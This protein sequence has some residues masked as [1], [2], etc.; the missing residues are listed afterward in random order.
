[1]TSIRTV[2]ISDCTI[3]DVRTVAEIEQWFRRAAC[4]S[5]PPQH[6]DDEHD[7]HDHDDG[8]NA[9]KH[10]FSS[11]TPSRDGAAGSF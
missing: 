3:T 5:A 8:S 6:Q 9:D 10:G 11:D 4:G 2:P 1:M 7:D